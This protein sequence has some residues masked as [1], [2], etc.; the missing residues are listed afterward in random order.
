LSGDKVVGD[1]WLPVDNHKRIRDIRIGPE[2]AVYVLSD[3]GK[4]YKPT[5]K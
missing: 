2:S 3:E 5:P 4:L 1:R